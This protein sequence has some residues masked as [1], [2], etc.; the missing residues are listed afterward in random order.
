MEFYSSADQRADYQGMLDNI[1]EQPDEDSSTLRLAQHI[2]N[3]EP[4]SVLEIGCGDGRLF[5]T[6]RR[7]G[8][9]GEYAGVEVAE[10][11][12]ER[13]RE[14]HPNTT[15][16][17]AGAYNLPVQ[18]ETIEMVCAE[19]VLEHLVYPAEALEEMMRVLRPGGALVL[20]F[21]DFVSAGRMASQMLGLAPGSTALNRLRQGR[22]I[23]AVVSLYD[24][25]MRLSS[26]LKQAR[27]NYGPF[28]VNLRPKC[29]TYPQIVSPDVDAVYI[30]SKKE[31]ADWARDRGYTV[32]FPWG[33]ETRPFY[34]T[35]H[36]A[37]LKE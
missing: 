3:I 33:T 9:E 2:A 22:P 19:F 7:Q 36:L 12:I 5:R 34:E 13:N 20:I 10:Y 23:D 31:F 1:E 16:Y 25:R 26:A 32:E 37:I 4:V 27:K 8:Y 14:R 17:T 18:S 6:L 35:A 21:P 28:P 30:A 15:W 24:S 11:I 29:L